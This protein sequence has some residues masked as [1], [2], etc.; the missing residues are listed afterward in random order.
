M[1]GARRHSAERTFH[2]YTYDFLLNFHIRNNLTRIDDKS[3]VSVS[4]LYIHICLLL[5][6]VTWFRRE[7][8]WRIMNIYYIGVSRPWAQRFETRSHHTWLHVQIHTYQKYWNHVEYSTFHI[9][10]YHVL[11]FFSDCLCWYEKI[12][13]VYFCPRF[14]YRTASSPTEI[15]ILRKPINHV[16]LLYMNFINIQIQHT[17]HFVFVACYW[18]KL[19]TFP[20]S[21]LRQ[22]E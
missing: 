16:E 7:N 4:E 19:R 13:H 3:T 18:Q 8:R 14:K 5:R 10:W 1:C 21:R 6:D 9:N 2:R 17:V 12:K 22:I 20:M 11:L 15:V